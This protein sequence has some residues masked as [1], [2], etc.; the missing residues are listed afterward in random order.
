M[1]DACERVTDGHG[2]ERVTEEVDYTKKINPNPS[3]CLP[4]HSVKL[5]KQRSDRDRGVTKRVE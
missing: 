5:K 4:E 1:K 3:T 2:G